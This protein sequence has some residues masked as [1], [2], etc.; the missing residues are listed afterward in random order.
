VDD[1]ALDLL[2][3]AAAAGDDRA[4]GE[5][6]AATQP[7]VHRLCAH[8]GSA[9][10]ADDLTQETYLRALRSLPGYRGEAPVRTWLLSIAR[11]VCADHVRT[12]VRRSRIDERLV[13]RPGA[14]ADIGD[15]AVVGD[16]LAHIDADQAAAFALTQ[17]LGLDY[18][19]AAEVCDCPVGTIRS[20]VARARAALLAELGHDGRDGARASAT[21]SPPR[22]PAAGA[23]PA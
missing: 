17:V 11:H 16:L 8:L 3:R 22:R 4:L 15:R 20:R 21:G 12:R 23:G 6:V 19:E 9:R 10:D 14:V 7:A 13:E 5:L 1:A 2:A 18:A